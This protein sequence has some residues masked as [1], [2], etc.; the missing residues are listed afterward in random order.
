ML[1]VR[2]FKEKT[3]TLSC[4]QNIDLI[5]QKKIESIPVIYLK[6]NYCEPNQLY[7]YHT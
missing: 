6:T 1:K 4:S 5:A 3:S 7:L 2:V